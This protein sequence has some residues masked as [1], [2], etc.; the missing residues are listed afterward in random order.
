[1]EQEQRLRD[2]NTEKKLDKSINKRHKS[3]SRWECHPDIQR[4]TLSHIHHTQRSATVHPSR[5]LQDKVSEFIRRYPQYITSYSVETIAA[6]MI[7][8]M[9]FFKLGYIESP[10]G[11]YLVYLTWMNWEQQQKLRDKPKIRQE[12]YNV[13]EQLGIQK[14]LLQEADKVVAKDGDYIERVYPAGLKDSYNA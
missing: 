14:L 1:M 6:N 12:M 9:V 4:P 10:T 3:M 11:P 5:V 8:V 13:M 7:M 2:F